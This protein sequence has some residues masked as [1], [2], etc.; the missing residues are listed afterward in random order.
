MEAARSNFGP[1][2]VYHDIRPHFP[3]HV[4]ER[5]L[6]HTRQT[7]DGLIHALDVGCGT[8]RAALTLAQEG[9]DSV[10]AAD[11]DAEMLAVLARAAGDANLDRRIRLMQRSGE[12]LEGIPSGSVNLITCFDSFHWMDRTKALREFSRVLRPRGLLAVAWNDLCALE[13][14][15]TRFRVPLPNRLW[16]GAFSS[17]GLFRCGEP[18][19]I[20]HSYHCDPAA[21]LSLCRTYRFGNLRPRPGQPGHLITSAGTHAFEHEE[22]AE[23]L[24]R[25]LLLAHQEDAC[26]KCDEDPTPI[27]LAYSTKLYLARKI[28]DAERSQ[29]DSLAG[30]SSQRQHKKHLIRTVSR[31]AMRVFAKIAR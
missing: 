7:E 29:S 27:P 4:F 20:E 5:V 31:S 24:A 16:K 21:L 10:I 13:T 25:E 3:K 23:T 17:T 26:G 14:I 19:I 18:E 8:G 2:S 1:A 6:Q 9:C 12:C 15:N 30:R 28:S 22:P 11:P